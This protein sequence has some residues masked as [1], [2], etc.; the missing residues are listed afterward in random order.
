MLSFAL[1][2]LSIQDIY[3]HFRRWHL[4]GIIAFLSFSD[5]FP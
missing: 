5:E 1:L 2:D 3:P 4:T